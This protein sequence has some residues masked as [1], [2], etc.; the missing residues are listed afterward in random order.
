MNY[1][2]FSEENH[3]ILQKY[4]TKN[5]FYRLESKRTKSGFT[6]NHAIQSG[7]INLDSSLGIYAGDDETYRVFA[8]IFNPVINDY[9]S[10]NPNN[11][12]KSDLSI[13]QLNNPDPENK[14]ILSTR[15]RIARNIAGFAFTTFIDVKDRKKLELQVVNALKLLDNNLKGCYI[16]MG[17]ISESDYLAFNKKHLIFNRGDKFQDAAGI[18]RD[19]PVSRGIFLSSNRKFIV[20]VNEEDH[21][22]IISMEN[23]GK[24]IEAFKRI[25]AALPILEKKLIFSCD[26]HLGYL[27]TCPSNLGTGMRAGVHIRLPELNEK[28][29]ILFKLAGS[30]HLQ[31]RGTHGEKTKIKNAVFD[32]SN[33]Q[34]LGITERQCIQTLYTGI[35]NIIKMEKNLADGTINLNF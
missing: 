31:I 30:F 7:I 9:H 18:N 12:H 3:S 4:L 25:C 10:F 26:R 6:L 22:R 33:K 24:I 8:E 15:I 23:G 32:I 20:W 13:P 29:E 34:R 5:I 16:P 35:L 19:W 28:Q 1:P 11:F 2:V 21:L 14:Y 17:S 27:T